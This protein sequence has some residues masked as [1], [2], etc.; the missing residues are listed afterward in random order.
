MLSYIIIVHHINLL[1]KPLLKHNS[2]EDEMR[3]YQGVTGS[4]DMALQQRIESNLIIADVLAGL[5]GAFTGWC[6]ALIIY[7]AFTPEAVPMIEHGI[8][9]GPSA[10]GL[11]IGAIVGVILVRRT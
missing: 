6:I 1:Q 2:S 10:C 9:A 11:I 4:E 5:L 8:P 3:N 7:C